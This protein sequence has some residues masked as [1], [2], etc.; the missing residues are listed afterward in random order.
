MIIP[1]LENALEPVVRRQRWLW[2]L[3]G[4]SIGFLA[5]AL[6]AVAFRTTLPLPITLLVI[7]ALLMIALVARLA[8]NWNPDYSAIARSI[9]QRHP[10]LHAALLT[11]IEQRP[12]PK[13][14]KLHFL[15]QRVIADAVL[16]RVARIGLSV[17][18]GSSAGR[19]A[20][21]LCCAV[22]VMAAARPRA[23]AA[24]ASRRGGRFARSAVEV[25]L[26]IRL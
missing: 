1:L 16:M 13:T 10:E 8:E 11:A 15:Q 14:G 24:T 25:P 20:T 17:P 3:R 18:T 2:K 9:E 26:A 6:V 19:G 22:F 21:L 23:R 12:D 5:V 7:G 4:W